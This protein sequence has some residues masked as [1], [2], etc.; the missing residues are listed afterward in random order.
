MGRFGSGFFAFPNP[1]VCVA[2]VV[3]TIEPMHATAG[4]TWTWRM[5]HADYPSADGW[6]LSYAMR[7]PSA[8]AWDATWISTTSGVHTVTI[9]AS[10]TADLAPGGYELTRVWTLGAVVNHQPVPP[11]TVAPNPVT[12]AAGERVSHAERTLAVIEAALGGRLT[13]DIAYYQI[14]GRAVQKIPINELYGLRARYRLEVYRERNPGRAYQP[15]SIRFVG[16]A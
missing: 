13:D 2:P 6:V 16:A 9:P 10:A 15:V 14:A 5:S 12:A 1:G 8:P 3:P 4:A 7:G 11:L